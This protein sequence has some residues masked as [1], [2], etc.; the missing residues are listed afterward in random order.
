MWW[1]ESESTCMTSPLWRA[2]R[3]YLRSTL[4]ANGI[5]DLDVPPAFDTPVPDNE[6]R[7]LDNTVP[8]YC[9]PR[10]SSTECVRIEGHGSRERKQEKTVLE[11]HARCQESGW[12]D[13]MA[14]WRYS[15]GTVVWLVDI[16]DRTN[17]AML[18]PLIHPLAHAYSS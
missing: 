14:N 8:H 3:C 10:L 18:N 15:A 16:S 11:M 4:L 17:F 13:H 7:K 12:D 5:S 9:K 2:T 1:G 6:D